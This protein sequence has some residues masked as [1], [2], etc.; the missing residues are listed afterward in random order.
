MY[1][2]TGPDGKGWGDYR[3]LIPEDIQNYENIVQTVQLRIPTTAGEERVHQPGDE[4][5]KVN[6]FLLFVSGNNNL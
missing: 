2:P 1:Q 6:I 4:D 3:T 5:E